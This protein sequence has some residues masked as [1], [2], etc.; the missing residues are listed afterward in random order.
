MR[1]MTQ[2]QYLALRHRYRKAQRDDAHASTMNSSEW[3]RSNQRDGAGAIRRS[4]P[5][6]IAAT[7]DHR[8]SSPVMQRSE[9]LRIALNRFYGKRHRAQLAVR[10]AS[11]ISAAMSKSRQLDGKE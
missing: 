10:Q 7:L 1:S 11:A 9:R 4:V 8:E 2:A 6:D 5:A 3:R